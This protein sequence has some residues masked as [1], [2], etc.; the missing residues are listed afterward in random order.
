MKKDSMTPGTPLVI[1]APIA[2]VSILQDN[3]GGAV[4]AVVF[5]AVVSL[6]LHVRS[7]RVQGR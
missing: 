6:V 1:G 3:Y 2:A 7:S 5:C 4:F